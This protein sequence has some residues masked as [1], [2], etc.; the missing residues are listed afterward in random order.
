M[1]VPMS[2]Y[3]VAFMVS[4]LQSTGAVM[5]PSGPKFQ[6]KLYL[7]NTQRNKCINIIQGIWFIIILKKINE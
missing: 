1:T 4:D 7:C 2:T 6:V 5:L 3:L